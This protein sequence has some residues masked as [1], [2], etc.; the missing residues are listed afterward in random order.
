MPSDFS[1]I[2]DN[3]QSMVDQSAPAE[4]IDGYLNTEGFTPQEFKK[5]NE[6]YGTFMSAIKRGGKSTGSLIADFLPA[7]GADLLGKIAPESFKPALE[8]YKEKQMKEAAKTQE[9]MK[10][11]PAEFESYQDIKSPLD[12][13]NYAKE[14]IGESIPS[15]LPGVVTGGVGAVAGRGAII[16][17]GEAAGSKAAKEYLASQAAKNVSEKFAAK[18]AAEIGSEAAAS[19]IAKK[20]L[21]VEAGSALV[22]SAALNMPDAYQAVYDPQIQGSLVPAL[23]SGA[24][25]SVLDAITPFN[26]LRKMKA[27]KID[28]TAVAGAW[29]KQGAKEL[30]KGFLT[31]GATETLQEM[32]NA[33][34]EQFVKGNP[35]FFTPENLTRFIDAGLKG[36][37]G[38][39]V[40]QGGVGALTARNAPIAKAPPAPSA[41]SAPGQVA[42]PAIQ[43]IL[44]E[45]AVQGEQ[46]ELFGAAPEGRLPERV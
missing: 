11:L 9:E 41:P 33:K 35:E 2:K 15:M 36:G 30:G 28:P 5:A 39:G 46:G 37:L 7:M 22:G 27:G 13:L 8:Q 19:A 40:M 44:P 16:A 45:G 21:Q 10:V 18:R 24:F 38:G 32:S 25:N 23:A 14:A 17:A 4:H 26:L 20:T 42:A 31:E 12:A 29:Y 43:P 1:R 34:A 6:N 3:V